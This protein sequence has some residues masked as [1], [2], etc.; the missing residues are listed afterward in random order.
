MS[1]IQEEILVWVVCLNLLASIF[2]SL[3]SKHL[4]WVSRAGLLLRLFLTEES[5]NLWGEA[6]RRLTSCGKVDVRKSLLQAPRP[7]FCLFVC[8]LACLFVFQDRVSLC[9]PGCPGT[10]SI[11]QDAPELRDPP[12][13]ASWMLGLK[14]CVTTTWHLRPLL[15]QGA[16]QTVPDDLFL[17]DV[18]AEPL[19]TFAFRAMGRWMGQPEGWERASQCWAQKGETMTLEIRHLSNVCQC[20]RRNVLLRPRELHGSGPCSITSSWLSSG[21]SFTSDSP[22]VKGN[23][24]SAYF[25]GVFWA[26]DEI[27]NMNMKRLELLVCSCHPLSSGCL[28]TRLPT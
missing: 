18:T 21:L 10:R 9:R 28:L 6:G 12:A 14:A 15:K 16:L 17:A 20:S 3:P 5:G 11:H 22:S 24:G 26:L 7:L 13:S 2:L 27:L 1:W 19:G 23:E 25:I 4:S 8:L